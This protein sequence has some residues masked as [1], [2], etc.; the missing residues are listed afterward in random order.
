MGSSA[1]SDPADLHAAGADHRRRSAPSLARSAGLASDLRPRSLQADSRADRRLSDLATCRSRS[2]RSTSPWSS[3]RGDRDLLRRDDLSVAPGGAARSRAGAADISDDATG[4]SSKSSGL[5][6]S[7]L[8]GKRHADRA[9]RSSLTVER[10]RWWRSSARRA[11]ARARCCTCSAGSTRSDGGSIRDRSGWSSRALPDAEL[12]AFRNR[13]VGFVFQFHHLLPEFTALENAE[14]PMRIARRPAAERRERAPRAART[15]S[16]WASGS[17][18]G[19]AC[20]RAA[21]SSASRSRAR[22]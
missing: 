7:Y 15:A 19:R 6:K 20:C 1:A 16:V 3:C 4:A 9:A 22:W 2:S 18:T 5:A 17:S 11:S 8:V 10:A 13:H 12:V 21:S 14:M